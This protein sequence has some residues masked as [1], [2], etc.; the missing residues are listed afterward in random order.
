MRVYIAG[1]MTGYRDY[2]FAAFEAAQAEW[3]QRGHVAV[4]P[5]DAGDVVWMRHFGRRFN[6]ATD[7]CDYGDP[8][9][10]EIFVEDIRHLLSAEAILL[11]HGWERST[12]ACIERRIAE[13]FGLD[14][15]YECEPIPADE[16]EQ[17][18]AIE[19]AMG[20]ATV[21]VLDEDEEC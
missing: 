4:T 3:I 13:A 21:G 6:G 8:L 14:V 11:L 7:K 2:N 17:L 12:G 5:F 20:Q 9:L 19:E 1:P 10:R 16:A 18:R 15:F